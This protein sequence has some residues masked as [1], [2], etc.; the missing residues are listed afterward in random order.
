MTAALLIL[1]LAVAVALLVGARRQ[2]A[3]SRRRLETAVADHEA[4][5]DETRDELARRARELEEERVR[6]EDDRLA[7]EQARE[8]AE[9]AQ[10]RL[11]RRLDVERRWN[12]EL[13]ERLHELHVRRGALGDTSDVR[14]LVLHIAVTLLG[15]EKG[16]LLS[17]SDADGDG[18][19][20]LVCSEGFE[21][22]PEHSAVAQHF[23]AQVLDRDE[24]VRA[25]DLDELELA[26]RTPADL[27]I[28]NLVA[29]PVYIHDRF[30][31]VVVCANKPGGFGE[32]DDDV[33]LAL[34]DHAG[35][36]L[37]NARLRGEVRGSYLATVRVLA[38]AV[39]AKD[40]ALR[41]HANEVTACVLAVAD[42]VGVDP[43][44]RED[45]TF[46]AL[47][48][49]VGKL[50]VSERIL[51]KPGPL[52]PEERAAV[53]EHPR[54]GHRLIEQVPALR[55]I[56]PAILHHHERWDGH[57]YPGRLRGEDIP[58]VARL[59]CVAD[60]FSAMREE[61]PYR[62]PLSLD[63]ACEELTRCAGTQF[64]P[65]VVRHFV[66]E[67]RRRP[68]ELVAG[69]LERAV[70]GSPHDGAL[71]GD[72]AVSTVDNLTLLYGHRFLH[73]LAASEATRAELQKRPFAVVHVELPDLARRNRE[74]SYAAGDALLRDVAATLQSVA[75]RSGGTAARESGSR[76]T[77][78][79]PGADE[80]IAEQL[81][82]EL[83]DE[84]ADVADARVSHA[85]W[86]AGDTGDAVIERARTHAT[87]SAV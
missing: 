27:E 14:A 25:D 18:H 73:E 6:A 51:L 2:L 41:G 58:L 40:R 76:L 49:D 5:L 34:G 52:T 38:D 35:T 36:A 60:A 45:L 78:L 81:A 63:E 71:L 62:A 72:G 1:A 77:L 59:I 47:L 21:H 30:H 84:L 7:H 57:G 16:L 82:A 10:A 42:R 65:N 64:D 39:E 11:R 74:E 85:V 32:Y 50:A 79:V 4:R 48:H 69:P 75:A 28:D 17:R 9:Q 87:A 22:D 37:D 86:R 20:D 68:P 33:L 26:E 53:E 43:R 46:A 61:R 24:T 83:A 66:D 8:Q 15:A 80:R 29:V 19:L 44:D 55:G 54:V 3:A 13:R 23:A 70:S 56:G 67:V 31:G 12:E